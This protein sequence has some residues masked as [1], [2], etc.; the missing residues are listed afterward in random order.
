MIKI[1]QFVVNEFQ[2]NAFVLS[3]ETGE[4]VIIDG[5]IKFSNE[6][7]AILD[8][9]KTNKLKVKYIINTHGHIDHI[10]GNKKLKE[11][12]GVPVLM[13]SEDIFLV[14]SAES[15]ARGYGL[16]I[17]TQPIP[18]VNISD[19]STIEFGNSVLKC[20]QVP[21]HTPGSICF[22]SE[23]DAFVITGDA[24]FAGSIG[25]T[26]LPKGDYNTLITSIKERL[27]TLPENT[28]VFCGHGPETSIGEEKLHNPF[29]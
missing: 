6:K 10:C 23:S 12:F 21:G 25:R 20:I 1:K 3:D 18:D 22:Y 14:E 29:L 7:D 11:E 5:A 2:V 19:N 26:D 17:D 15:H 9:I 16:S 27:T 13:N 28:K 4:A 24:L 8:Y